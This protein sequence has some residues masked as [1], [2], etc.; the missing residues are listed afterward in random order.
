MDEE[1][2][3]KQAKRNYFV[4][5]AVLCVVGLLVMIFRETVVGLLAGVI[6]GIILCVIG[7]IEIVVYI[8]TRLNITDLIIGILAIAAGIVLLCD[9]LLIV[10]VL[11]ILLGLYLILEGATKIKTA[12][13][14]QKDG[15][16]NWFILLIVAVIGIGLGIF[17][18]VKPF[19]LGNGFIFIVGLMLFIGGLLN[20]LHGV[21]THKILQEEK[22]NVVDMED[23]V[24]KNNE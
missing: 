4:I 17:L 2:K 12:V 10:K 3:L 1:S 18:L 11:A 7:V 16:K 22:R 8:R 9:R 13:M 20:L 24:N 6:P 14:A 19:V 21:Y 5:A 15:I 23:Y